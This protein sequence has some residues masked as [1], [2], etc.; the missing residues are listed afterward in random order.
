[1]DKN[2]GLLKDL[3]LLFSPIF[4]GVLFIVFVIAMAVA[5][6]IENDFGA[7]SARQI[8]YN[9]RWFELIFIL[10][11]INMTG[12]IF[13]FKLYRRSKLTVLLF[14]LAFIV[15]I[16][17]AGITR[18]FGYEGTVHIREGQSADYGLSRDRYMGLEIADEKGNLVFSIRGIYQMHQKKSGI[19]QAEAP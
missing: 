14:H 3:K 15:M 18:Y 17:G 11:V 12:Q 9:S 16:V 10:M 2:R 5:T 13:S 8:I 1:M 6:F 19:F 7:A 4:T